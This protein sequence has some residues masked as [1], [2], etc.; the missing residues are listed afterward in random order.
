MKTA[1]LAN[2]RWSS[3]SSTSF[4]VNTWRAGRL[5]QVSARPHGACVHENPPVG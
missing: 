2:Y 4:E 3:R 1:T 5:E